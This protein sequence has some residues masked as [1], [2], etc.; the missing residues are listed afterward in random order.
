MVEESIHVVFDESDNR[1][2]SKHFDDVY[3]DELDANDLSEVKKKNMQDTIQ[4]LDE[5]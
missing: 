4:S 1:I 3:D 5:A 2:L